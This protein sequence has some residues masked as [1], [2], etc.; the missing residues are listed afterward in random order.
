MK[1]SMNKHTVGN[2]CSY[3]K[4]LGDITDPAPWRTSFPFGSSP[5]SDVSDHLDPGFMKSSHE[6]NT[7]DLQ[8][9]PVSRYPDQYT[10][11]GFSFDPEFLTNDTTKKR[12][13]SYGVQDFFQD[14]KK[15]KL[16]IEYNLDMANVLN[17]VGK[18]VFDDG[19]Q[20][21]PNSMSDQDRS[22]YLNFMESLKLQ[23]DSS[24]NNDLTNYSPPSSASLQGGCGINV[25]DPGTLQVPLSESSTELSYG[26]DGVNHSLDPYVSSCT[27][28][29]VPAFP[30][31]TLSSNTDFSGNYS[32]MAPSDVDFTFKFPTDPTGSYLD[33]QQP[34]LEIDTNTNTLTNNDL[35]T[36]HSA[37]PSPSSSNSFSSIDPTSVA[38]NIPLHGASHNNNVIIAPSPKKSNAGRMDDSPLFRGP[39]LSHPLY[40]SMGPQRQITDHRRRASDIARLQPSIETAHTALNKTSE[41]VTITV[42]KPTS[43]SSDSERSSRST[44][45]AIRAR[46]VSP[47]RTVNGSANLKV[48]S[49]DPRMRRRLS[50]GSV[51]STNKGTAISERRGV[52][53]PYRSTL[54]E[55]KYHSKLLSLLIQKLQASESSEQE[56][57]EGTGLEPN[58]EVKTT[59]SRADT[60]DA[61]EKL[62]AQI[63]AIH[64]GECNN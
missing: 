48:S 16:P 29:Y 64:I 28:E 25:N 58:S 17:V 27:S 56:S 14:V 10:Y 34:Y 19:V 31:N 57:G 12:S 50:A 22:A 54:D 40:T 55:R 24:I 18:Y 44:H 8:Q 39:G 15:Q 9:K 41:N 4:L 23:I 30:E 33:G 5:Y 35:N 63:N 3:R 37:S 26:I 21:I 38:Y 7:F 53:Q 49:E 36:L 6:Y 47:N 11:S 61:M 45:V 46:S 51:A 1:K 52:A 59:Y 2:R 32:A 20:Q 62:Q 42:S 13:H 60:G 43:P